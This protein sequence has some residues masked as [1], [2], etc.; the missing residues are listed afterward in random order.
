[1]FT[2]EGETEPYGLC[3]SQDCDD[4][5][6]GC[7]TDGECVAG[8]TADACGN[9]GDF[10]RVCFE[11]SECVSG[12]CLVE[13]S[14]RW[15]VIILRG[16]GIEALMPSGDPWDYFGGLPDPMVTV[17][18]EDDTDVFEGTTASITDSLT[19]V[20]DEAVLLDVPGRAFESMGMEVW[21][22]DLGPIN[23]SL[24]SASFLLGA[25]VFDGAERIQC[26]GPEDDSV[27]ITYRVRAH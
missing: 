12:Q 10:C 4:C 23:E 20:W 3:E 13:D 24:G 16:A 11:G 7:C 14:R 6:T 26:V 8:D 22:D 9:D 25:A 19:P 5:G 18:L 1:M 21:D 2:F 27:C 15:D 17:T